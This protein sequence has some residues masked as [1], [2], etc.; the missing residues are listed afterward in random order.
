MQSA[1]GDSSRRPIKSGQLL[2]HDDAQMWE[3]VAQ[4]CPEVG[5]RHVLILVAVHVAGPGDLLPSRPRAT[6]QS[7]R[8]SSH[9]AR[10]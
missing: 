10:R 9:K 3:V 7:F 2:R 1:A 4:S 6:A 8:R 5:G